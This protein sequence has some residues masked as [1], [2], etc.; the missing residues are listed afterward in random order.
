M[1]TCYHDTRQPSSLLR[2]RRLT[3]SCGT[4]SG[5]ASQQV[6]GAPG[7]TATGSQVAAASGGP[8][9]PDGSKGGAE[10]LTG[11]AVSLRPGNHPLDGT[12]DASSTLDA[13]CGWALC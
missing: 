9:V 4:P 5:V 6:T 11:V 8:S 12:S 10:G 7:G 13:K 3:R 2:S 1:G